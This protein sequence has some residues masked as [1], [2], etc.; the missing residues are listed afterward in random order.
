MVLALVTAAMLLVA[1]CV[2]P[3]IRNYDYLDFQW[4]LCNRNEH[5]GN[6][7]TTLV[8]DCSDSFYNTGFC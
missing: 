7:V 6:N 5:S 2:T 1:G 4:L 8:C 3:S